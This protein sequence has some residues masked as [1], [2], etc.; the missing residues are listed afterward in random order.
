MLSD[1]TN[2][3]KAKLYDFAYT[4]FMSSV[5]ISWLILNHKYILIY[6]SDSKLAEKLALLNNYDFEVSIFGW[7]DLPASLNFIIP[8]LFGLFYVFLYP[9]ISEFFYEWTLESKKHLKEI[10]QKIEDE[11]PLTLSE[12]RAIKESNKDLLQELDEYKTRL[13]ASVEESKKSIEEYS[14]YKELQ[15]KNESLHSNLEKYKHDVQKVETKLQ[16][17]IKEKEELQKLL[18]NKQTQ[19]TI[20]EP[21]SEEDRFLKVLYDANYKPIGK[22][23]FLD[24]MVSSGFSRPKAE[25]LL[26]FNLETGLLNKDGYKDI[27]LTENGNA[28]LLELFETPQTK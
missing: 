11:T 15:A 3:I 2:S 26:Q 12:S 9:Y 19:T 13:F 14:R 24:L 20:N 16:D 4:P 6:F 28:K 25:K 5:I 8:L 1:I 23:S 27:T 7:I 22:S 10:K 21:L 17:I 18:N